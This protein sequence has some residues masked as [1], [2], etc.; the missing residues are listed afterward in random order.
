MIDL[1]KQAGDRLDSKSLSG[2]F[3]VPVVEISALRGDGLEELVRAVREAARSP[4]E[5][6]YVLPLRQEM[7]AE[8]KQVE[9]EL[10][11][12]LPA[13]L[14]GMPR[15]WWAQKLLEQDEKALEEI[16]LNA[17]QKIR[18]EA[19]ET[20]LDDDVQSLISTARYQSIADIM[21]SIYTRKDPQ[22]ISSPI[23]S[24]KLS[25]TVF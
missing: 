8:I 9:K 14:H 10:E 20:K 2:Y 16:P 3:G 25:R 18:I 22:R 21:A 13:K 11:T 5:S 19:L 1:V 4:Q 7:E 12:A 17:E 24:I 15:R 6:H 23:G